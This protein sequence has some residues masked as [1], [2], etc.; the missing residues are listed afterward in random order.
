V[1]VEDIVISHVVV[2]RRDPCGIGQDRPALSWVTSTEALDWRQAGAE[3]EIDGKRFPV[4]GATS[5]A[6]PWPAP[7]LR[8]RQQATVRVRVTGED[9]RQSAWSEPMVVEAGLLEA[10]DWTAQL[11]GV[12]VPFE[13]TALLRRRFGIEDDVVRARLYVTAHGVHEL[14]LNGAVVGDHVLD[15]GW[16]SY[17]HR[18]RYQSFDVT[19]VVRPGP[20]VL[21]ARLA[22]G[23]YRGRLGF[24]GGRFAHYGEQ[25]GLLAQLEVVTA[26]GTLVVETDG[27]W[28]WMS[29]P[30]TR[31]SIYDG[32]D[33]DARLE[34]LGWSSP[35][36]DDGAWTPVR[37]LE[38]EHPIPH[39][40]VGP[41]VRRTEEVRPRAITTSP[42]G[43]T[44]VDFGQN[45]VGRLRL[46]VDGPAGTQVTLRHAEILEDGELCTEPL[47]HAEA[48]DRYTLRGGGREAWE[49]RFT[50]HGFRYAEVTG[51]PGELTDDDVVAVVCHTDLRRTGWF[52]CSDP[53]VE[54]LHE[55][56]VWSLRGNALDLP[57]DC[58][59][60]DERLGWTGD[61]TVFA[62]T[63]CFLYDVDAFLASWLADLAAEQDDQQ[64]VPFVVPNILDDLWIGTAV[65]GDAAVE[66]PWRLYEQYGDLEVLAD[67]YPSMVRWVEL[68]LR[69]AGPDRHWEAPFQFGDWL[70]PAAPADDPSAARTDP[71]LVANAW[72]CHSLDLL[73]RTAEA[74]GKAADA[75]RYQGV[76]AEARAAFIDHYAA[77]D[78][79]LTS[80]A[81]TAYALAIRFDLVDPGPA[82]ERLAELVAEEGHRIATGF[83][84][85]PFVCGAL[86]D[87]GHV[88]DAYRLLLQTESP[89]WL[90]PVLHGATTIWER[91]DGIG[92]DGRRNPGEMNS[93]NH[94]ALGAVADWL[95]RTVAGLAPAEPG[96]RRLL[97][98]PVPGPGIDH[99]AAAHD[100]PYGRAEVS[101]HRTSEG[102]TVEASVPPNT[103]ATVVLPDRSEP[104]VVGSGHHRWL[105]SEGS[106]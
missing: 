90:Y 106:P 11:I 105:V 22:D 95:H 10:S 100:T 4:E 102:V 101:W 45:L 65:W 32:E 23:W 1:I 89:S 67:Q 75:E 83:V 8:S 29:G 64:G 13:A 25:L 54:R 94:Y 86:V 80:D 78:G 92:P 36:F 69:W 47:R 76:A 77:S 63:A 9:G 60:R 71:H 48:T 34:P 85:T 21:G 55:N 7:P 24:E 27:D 82:G 52:T 70:D 72:L 5:V 93:F 79:R 56:I 57:T 44:I 18:L 62:P 97:V 37:M 15:P 58:P 20:N 103:S 59:Q 91:W 19:D 84:G 41:P 16:T 28:R 30:T 50:F 66:V 104:F 61:L 98:Q 46:Q 35:D 42:S 96:Y 14:S 43:R 68:V 99:A 39:A 38:V 33:H 81:A 17:H 40:A 53:R 87:T 12:D 74:L 6:F 73:A 26:A 31:A 51:W 3:V 49:P 88:E 2:G